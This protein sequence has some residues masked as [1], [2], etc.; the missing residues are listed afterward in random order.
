MKKHVENEHAIDLTWY[1][2]KVATTKGSRDGLK[3]AKVFK[4]DYYKT[5][6]NTIHVKS[7]LIEFNLTN[8]IIT[9]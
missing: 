2:L 3:K 5:N 1:K 9:M 4:K 8:K 6:L 7:L